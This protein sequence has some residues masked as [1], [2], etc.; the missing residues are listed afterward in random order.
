LVI[1]QRGVLQGLLF[2]VLENNPTQK[3]L[4]WYGHVL[5]PSAEFVDFICNSLGF[6]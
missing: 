1:A 3:L 5:P 6:F 4:S 2:E